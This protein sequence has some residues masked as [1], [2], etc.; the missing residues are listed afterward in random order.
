MSCGQSPLGGRVDLAAILA[1]LRRHPRESEGL[2]DAFLG[3]AGKP[4]VVGGAEQAVLVE[5][6]PSVERAVAQRD[7][8]RL[9]SGEVLQRGAAALG[10]RR[11]AG[12]P[13]SR[14]E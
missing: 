7:V 12:R 6:Q 4:R 13:D 14:R 9:R 11:A 8:V 1:K 2:V 5:L 3:V 10:R